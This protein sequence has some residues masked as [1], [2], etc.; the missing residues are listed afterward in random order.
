MHL[1]RDCSVTLATRYELDGPEIESR[2]RLDLSAPVQTG[3]Q[4]HPV[5][6]EIAIESLS[7]A[8]VAGT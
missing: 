3:T 7:W 6:Y 4:A 8:K 1:G 2:W 5:S